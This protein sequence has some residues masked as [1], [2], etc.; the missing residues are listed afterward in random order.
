MNVRTSFYNEQEDW[1]ITVELKHRMEAVIYR[2]LDREGYSRSCEVSVAFV[3]EDKIRALNRDYRGRDSVTDVLSFSDGV[4]DPDTGVIL[5]GDVVI[6]VKRALEQAES[7]GHS[8][9]REMCFLAAHSTLHLL[10]YDHEDEVDEKIMR[11]KQTEVLA[12]LG[13]TQ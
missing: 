5:L 1:P 2:T 13:I 12:S 7:Y 9:E 3:G 4:V 8:M 6:C 10:G 11:T